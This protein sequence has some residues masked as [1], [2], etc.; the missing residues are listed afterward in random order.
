MENEAT[1]VSAYV[2]RRIQSIIESSYE[3]AARATLAKLRRGIG[4]PP[5]SMPEIWGAT[6]EDLPDEMKSKNGVPT[7][8]EW[9]VHTAL[10]LYA[11]HQQGRDLHK[12]PMSCENVSLGCAIRRLVKSKEDEPRVKRRFDAAATSDDLEEFSYHLRGLVEL[13]KT[14]DVPLDYPALTRDLYWFQIPETRDSVRLSWGQD[15]YRYSKTEDT[16]QNDTRKDD[17]DNEDQ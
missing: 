17:N 14:E 3:S 16:N 7:I 10:T 1:L 5:G 8:C 11:L 15:F 12:K 6:L 9:A 2:R 4:K 13:L